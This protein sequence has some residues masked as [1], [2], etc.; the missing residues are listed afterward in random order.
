MPVSV[1]IV[2]IGIFVAGIFVVNIIVVAVHGRVL[3]LAV[4]ATTVVA[5]AA[6]PVTASLL[7]LLL[8]TRPTGGLAVVRR[9]APDDRLSDPS[10][11][12]VL[13]LFRIGVQQVG[14]FRGGDLEGVS[15]SALEVGRLDGRAQSQVDHSVGRRVFVGAIKQLASLEQKESAA[16]VLYRIVSLIVSYR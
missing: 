9:G 14:D 8:D 11:P 10:D 7:L 2:E 5:G 4:D 15:L 1:S 12:V 16:P 3:V 13:F 6:V